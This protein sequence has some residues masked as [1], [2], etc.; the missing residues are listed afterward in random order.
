M[1]HEGFEI[2]GIAQRLENRPTQRLG[3]IDF[4]GGGIAKPEPQNIS[5]DV[6]SLDNVLVH[7]VTPME[8]FD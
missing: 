2:P 8:P 4:S 6:P 7:S 5:A 3:K 1:N